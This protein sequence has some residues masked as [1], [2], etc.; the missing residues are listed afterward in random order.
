[1]KKIII[2]LVA[3]SFLITVLGAENVAILGFEKNDKASAYVAKQMTER[4]FEKILKDNDDYDLIG[5][6]E[7]QNALKKANVENVN[8]LGMD[9]RIAIGETLGADILIWG[10]VSSL[11][12]TDFK[13]NANI[14]SMKSA[15]VVLSSFNVGKN[16][17]ER[18]QIIE[19]ELIGKMHEFSSGEIDKLLSIGAQHFQSENYSA[20]ESTYKDVIAIEPSNLEANFYLGLISFINADYI[21]SEEYYLQALETEPDNNDVKDYLSKAYLKQD[22][23]DEAIDVLTE[24]AED[25]QDKEI[26]LRIGRIYGDNE[27]FDEALEAYDKAIEID[28]E[29]AEAFYVKGYLLYDLEE[30]EEAIVPFETASNAFP[31]DDDLQK[32]LATCYK[33]TGKLD[34]AI[35][36]Y[37]GIIEEQPDN[38]RA[39]MNLANAYNATEQYQEGL[40]VALTLNEKVHDNANVYILLATSYSYLEQYGNAEKNANKAIEIDPNQFQPYRIL[41]D[42][43]FAKGYKKYEAFLKLEEDAKAAYGEEADRLTDERD[44]VKGEAN[45]LFKKSDAFLNEDKKRTK[46]SSEL[47]YINSRKETL[48]KLLE[49]TKKDFF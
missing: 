42:V 49:V 29:Y 22:K 38:I 32:K 5:K 17:N 9:E 21:A 35:D 20:A 23:I 44:K 41:S 31:E 6:K 10:D 4:D 48:K 3:L 13:V 1:M 33:K 14:L 24:I 36:Q 19:T 25:N 26:W 16:K 46:N 11:S 28:P 34:A 15:E 47:K 45:D 7:T 37:K 27:Y 18:Y 40:D 12:N 2:L 39:Y 8:Y 43:Y 30:F